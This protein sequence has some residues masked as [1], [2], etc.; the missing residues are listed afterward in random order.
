M[1]LAGII[2][3]LRKSV[4]I[5][6]VLP[7]TGV[8]ATG[9]YETAR[10]EM[11]T[12]I[13]RGVAE[14][15]AYTGI[16]VLDE[17]VMRAMATVPRHEF[18]PV[19]MRRYAYINRALPIDEGQTISQPYIVALMTHLAAV[20]PDAVV[21]EIGTGSGYQAAVLALLARHV[22]SIEIIESLGRQA[23]NVLARLN[24][25]NVTVKIGDGYLGW[26][27]HAPYDAI[28]VTAAPEQVPPALLLQLRTG[29]RLVI[30]VGAQGQVQS[31]QVLEKQPDG[32]ATSREVLPVLFVP[33]VHGAETSDNGL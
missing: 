29:A 21:L 5:L 9:E 32:K 24:Y 2:H 1:S 3:V 7:W 18:V 8:Y 4:S 15:R 20:T 30:P 17:R 26:E 33:L 11:V 31:L 14:T 23:E 25:D 12:T 13:N 16:S 19:S 27:E 28:I 22:Y 6:L 10:Q